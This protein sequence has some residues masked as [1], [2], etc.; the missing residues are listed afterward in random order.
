MRHT[1]CTVFSPLLFAAFSIGRFKRADNCNCYNCHA[2][3]RRGWVQIHRLM[4]KNTP[5][6]QVSQFLYDQEITSLVSCMIN[7]LCRTLWRSMRQRA[8]LLFESTR[9]ED[10]KMVKIDFS[11]LVK[12]LGAKLRIKYRKE[13]PAAPDCNQMLQLNLPTTPRQRVK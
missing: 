6:P 5:A 8:L 12:W 1:S 9:K 10:P 7:A 2:C 13:L 4:A 3:H 11:V